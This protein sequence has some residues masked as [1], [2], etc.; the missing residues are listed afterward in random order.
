MNNAK[1]FV[2]GILVAELVVLLYCPST[3]ELEHNEPERITH[4]RILFN[5]D[6]LIDQLADEM[7]AEYNEAIRVAVEEREFEMAKSLSIE[8]YAQ[9]EELRTDQRELRRLEASQ[10]ERLAAKYVPLPKNK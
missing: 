4:E 6:K 2:L 1:Y 8:K 5:A 10:A 7:V 3:L 9:L